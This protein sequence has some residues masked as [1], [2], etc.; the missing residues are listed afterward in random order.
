ML[1]EEQL[2]LIAKAHALEILEVLRDTKEGVNYNDIFSK[3]LHS[4]V[5]MRLKGLVNAG[6]VLKKDSRYSI[7]E[8]GLLA[9]EHAEAIVTIT[10]EGGNNH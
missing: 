5:S 9:L 1:S 4:N 7:T 8:S 6:L 2:K 3:I 10:D